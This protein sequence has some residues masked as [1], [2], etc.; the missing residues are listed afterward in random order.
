M[1]KQILC[2]DDDPDILE[3]LKLLLVDEGYDVFCTT[4]PSKIFEL[5]QEF[6]PDLILLDIN[7]GQY[8]GLQICKAMRSYSRT[9]E[10]AILIISSDEAIENAVEEFGATDIILKPFDSKLLLEKINT[11]LSPTSS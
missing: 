4:S 8:N 10:I 6:K 3:L 2:I 9:G 7:L 11:Y 1:P 5:I